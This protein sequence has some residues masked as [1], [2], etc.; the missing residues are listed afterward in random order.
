ME[1]KSSDPQLPSNVNT[2]FNRTF[3]ELKLAIISVTIM[4]LFGFN[5]TFMELKLRKHETK[6]MV[7][8][9]FNRT[10]MELK[11]QCCTDRF[12]ARGV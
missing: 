12:A 5:R 3:M 9:G 6:I 10:F 1:L 7:W 2:R 4:D 11:Y 8:L